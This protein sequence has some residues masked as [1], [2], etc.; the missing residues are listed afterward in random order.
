[1]TQKVTKKSRL[2]EKGLK[3]VHRTPAPGNSPEENMV[4]IGV[5]GSDSPVRVGFALSPIHHF[6]NALFLK[7]EEA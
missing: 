7:A 4:L 3:M 2:S 5:P 1:L 6:F